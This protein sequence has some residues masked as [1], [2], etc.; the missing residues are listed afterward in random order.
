MIYLSGAVKK[1]IM[2]EPDFGFL[3]TPHIG[4]R[5]PEGATWA[6]D[7]GCFRHPESFNL[8]AYLRWMDRKGPRASSLFAN[9]PDVVGDHERTID[10]SEHALIWLLREGWKPSFVAQNGATLGNMP[11]EWFDALFIGGSI[12]WKESYEA[13]ALMIEAK[14]RGKHVHVGR[15]NTPER[16]RYAASAGA[17]SVD[18]TRLAFGF[19]ANWPFLRDSLRCINNQ[20][21]FSLAAA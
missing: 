13:S 5:L 12:A 3:L 17:D 7:T 21:S 15:V 20:L 16:M 6:A 19:N 1:Q 14:R 10:A 4:N 11:W 9:A 2:L 8:D 18:G